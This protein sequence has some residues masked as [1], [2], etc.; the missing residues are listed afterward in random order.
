MLQLLLCCRR[1]RRRMQMIYSFEMIDNHCFDYLRTSLFNCLYFS[2]TLMELFQL[3]VERK[4]KDHLTPPR[5]IEG[6][7]GEQQQDKNATTKGD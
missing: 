5:C 6:T 4:Y 1:R 7:K 3:W 2:E